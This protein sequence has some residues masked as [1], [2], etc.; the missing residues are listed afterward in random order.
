MTYLPNLPNNLHLPRLAAR[1]G[2]G[3]G[4]A[5]ARVALTRRGCDRR[6]GRE[7]GGRDVAASRRAAMSDIVR[8]KSAWCRKNFP[9][10]DLLW[11][12]S[13]HRSHRYI[14]N[15]FK[16][17]LKFYLAYQMIKLGHIY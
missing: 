15:F 12:I 14:D 5:A 10:R 2:N 8:T 16:K 17:I 11:A 1:V 3:E 9:P 13:R 6:G 7:G 4:A